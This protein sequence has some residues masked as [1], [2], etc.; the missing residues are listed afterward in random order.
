MSIAEPVR[1]VVMTTKGRR[2]GAL[3]ARLACAHAASSSMRAASV[4]CPY[5]TLAPLD[6]SPL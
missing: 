6:G 5:A 4:A 3:G 1:C 2:G